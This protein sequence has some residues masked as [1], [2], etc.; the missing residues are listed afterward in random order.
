MRQISLD[1]PPQRQCGPGSK[2]SLLPCGFRAVSPVYR[3]PIGSGYLAANARAARSGARGTIYANLHPAP[4]SA[5]GLRVR[6]LEQDRGAHPA[7]GGR[8]ADEMLGVALGGFGL[9]RPLGNVFHQKC[10][11]YRATYSRFAAANS[12]TSITMRWRTADRGMLMNAFASRS[13]S[14]LEVKSSI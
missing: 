8:A 1:R 2:S 11:G 14:P 7:A 13:P 5:M 6:T 9:R 3:S 4:A 12:V 10:D